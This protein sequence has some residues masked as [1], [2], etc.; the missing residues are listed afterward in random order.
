MVLAYVAICVNPNGTDAATTI[1]GF[2][3]TTSHGHCGECLTCDACI[4]SR[5]DSH[6]EHFESNAWTQIAHVLA[7]ESVVLI[8]P[9]LGL[10]VSSPI[11]V[12]SSILVLLHYLR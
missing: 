12:S 5:Y 6:L 7:L 10:L 8:D 2:F 4:F 3:G 11:L 1:P 9:P